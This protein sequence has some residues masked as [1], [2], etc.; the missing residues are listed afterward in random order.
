MLLVIRTMVVAAVVMA[1][2]DQTGGGANGR[3]NE[4]Q[5]QSQSREECDCTLS[6]SPRC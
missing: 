6:A 2:K 1:G 3:R 5:P 4:L